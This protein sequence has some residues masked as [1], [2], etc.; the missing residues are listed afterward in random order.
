MNSDKELV[1]KAWHKVKKDP[2]KHFIY[3]IQLV[4]ELKYMFM[5]KEINRLT[6]KQRFN[7]K[8]ILDE[9]ILQIGE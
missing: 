4:I 1:Y 9:T 7:I 2:E 3:H 8:Q 5:Y 6:D